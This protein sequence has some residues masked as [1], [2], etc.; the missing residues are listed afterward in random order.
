MPLYTFIRNLLNVLVQIANKIGLY[1]YI[2]SILSSH[3]LINGNNQLE[4]RFWKTEKSNYGGFEVLIVVIMKS[5]IFWD[6]T[7]CSSLKINRRFDEY[8]ASNFRVKE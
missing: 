2:Y 4:V 3:N 5:I 6:I 1:I 8:I 7:E